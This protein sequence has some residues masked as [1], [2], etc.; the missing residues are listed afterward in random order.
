MLFDR[1]AAVSCVL[2]VRDVVDRSAAPLIWVLSLLS[3]FASSGSCLLADREFGTGLR[4][5][6]LTVTGVGACV[7]CF[8]V[9][10]EPSIVMSDPSRALLGCK[11]SS[12][13]FLCVSNS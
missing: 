9:V 11:R 5:G 10:S 6:I 3:D 13:A 12:C 1:A 2:D 8:G 4:A 7:P